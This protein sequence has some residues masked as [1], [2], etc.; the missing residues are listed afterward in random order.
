MH[1]TANDD[2]YI[3]PC[4][5]TFLNRSWVDAQAQPI[6]SFTFD[7]THYRGFD[8]FRIVIYWPKYPLR[9]RLTIDDM[10]E[11]TI[12]IFLPTQD[13]LVSPTTDSVTIDKTTPDF[14]IPTGTEFTLFG[15][16]GERPAQ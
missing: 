15:M 9:I 14:T 4:M 5:A 2:R 7:L 11:Q 13:I 10:P 3:E 6:T 12:N 8:F 16:T 1:N